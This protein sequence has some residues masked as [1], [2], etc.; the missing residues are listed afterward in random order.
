MEPLYEQHLDANVSLLG[1]SELRDILVII[2]NSPLPTN[3]NR[4]DDKIRWRYSIVAI[5]YTSILLEKKLS[6][7]TCQE[8]DKLQPEVPDNEWVPN[9]AVSAQFSPYPRRHAQS[10][11]VGSG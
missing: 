7:K 11:N 1:Y 5:D 3:R 10:L 2:Y 8:N 6:L 9:I 4:I